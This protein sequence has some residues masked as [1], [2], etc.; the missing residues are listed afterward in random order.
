MK[1]RY[2]EYGAEALSLGL[3]MVSA[4]VFAAILEH[5]AS[6]VRHAIGSDFARRALMGLAMGSTAVGLIHSP[7]GRRSGAHMN[8]AVTLT[9]WS[10]G[11][12]ESVDAAL[13]VVSQFLGGLAGMLVG[14]LL[15][16]GLLADPKVNWVATVPGTGGPVVAF[17]AEV[18][19][20]FLMMA[21]ILVVSNT[22]RI[23]RFT[24]VVAG[25]LVASY[26]TLE[27][28]FSGMSM[29]P[30][31]T[32]G[33]AAAGN[34][35]TAFWVYLVAPVLAMLAAAALY[36]AVLV[37]LGRRVRCAKLYHDKTSPCPFRCGYMEAESRSS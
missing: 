12:V 35:W 25:T 2:P 7:W 10:L 27:A 1:L 24:G 32:F 5:P 11:K 20:A 4:S 6:P 26:I 30:A 34:V 17:G 15:L 31:R 19:I 36:R 9:F 28:P 37:P 21:T 14:W 16:G 3:F 23:A 33:S 18:G 13:Y 29:N 8:P 22:A